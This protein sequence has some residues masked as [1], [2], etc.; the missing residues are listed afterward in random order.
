MIVDLIDKLVDRVIQFVNYKK[1][2]RKTLLNDYITP[3]YEEF[4]IVH[5]AYLT[6]FNEYRNFLKEATELSPNSPILDTIEKDNL[7][8][9]KQRAKVFELTEAAQDE[10][11]GGFLQ[12]IYRYLVDT[13]V[14]ADPLSNDEKPDKQ[15]PDII[16]TQYWRRSLIREL[17]EIYKENWQAV[18]DPSAGRPPLSEE[19]IRHE[20]EQKYKQF[21]IEIEDAQKIEKLK[22]AL[23]LEALDSIVHEMQTQYQKVISEYLKVKKKLSW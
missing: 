18:I 21:R 14:A 6:S 8:N 22:R 2:S 16:Y 7:F 19:D 1:E 11:V 10:E 23:S 13:R 3:I 17:S 9:A 15:K 12:S 20:L 5:D 4:E